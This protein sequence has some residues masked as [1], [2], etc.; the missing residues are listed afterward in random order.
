MA[1]GCKDWCVEHPPMSSAEMYDPATNTW[2]QLPDLPMSISGGRME[3]LNGKPNT[4]STKPQM[5]KTKIS[6]A[7]RSL[8]Q[9]QFIYALI[10]CKFLSNQ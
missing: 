10:C 2:I 3:Q 7:P 8:N 6:S 9:Y 1:G 4:R 5:P